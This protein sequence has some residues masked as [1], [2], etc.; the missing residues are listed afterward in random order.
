M[1]IIIIIIRG[2]IH[3][4]YKSI[5]TY[6]LACLLTVLG[7]RFRYGMYAISCHLHRWREMRRDNSCEW[8]TVA[9]HHSLSATNASCPVHASAAKTNSMYS[10][11]VNK[12]NLS[13]WHSADIMMSNSI[14]DK[15]AVWYKIRRLHN[16]LIRDLQVH[17]E[18]KQ[19]DYIICIDLSTFE[20]V[21]SM[22]GW[23]I[24]CV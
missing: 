14:T 5:F 20:E 15:P 7:W 10:S 12:H 1:L 13:K 11:A 18:D 8:S 2:A 22:V 23:M 9:M 21:F 3:A 16:C 24:G 19:K 17:A 4:L 6:V